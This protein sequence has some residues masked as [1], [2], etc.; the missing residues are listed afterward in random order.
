METALVWRY[1]TIN[2]DE[3]VI[4]KIEKSTKIFLC[5]TNDCSKLH[6][7]RVAHEMHTLMTKKV[8]QVVFTK[9]SDSFIIILCL[10]IKLLVSVMTFSL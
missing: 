7:S 5:N 9:I 6:K 8:G 4:N 1:L 2:M 10:H 3:I